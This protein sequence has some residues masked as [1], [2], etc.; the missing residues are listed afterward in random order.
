MPPPISSPPTLDELR[1]YYA[2]LNRPKEM[3]SSPPPLPA[4]LAGVSDAE[5]KLLLEKLI[6]AAETRHT[7][8]P[9]PP[10]VHNVEPIV[11]KDSDPWAQFKSQ[12]LHDSVYVVT[13]IGAVTLSFTCP[14]CGKVNNFRR[15]NLPNVDKCKHCRQYLDLRRVDNGPCHVVLLSGDA[16]ID[17]TKY[18]LDNHVSVPIRHRKWKWV[19]LCLLVSGIAFVVSIA[20][21][22]YCRNKAEQQQLAENAEFAK[23]K[24]KQDSQKLDQEA[25]ATK[26]QEHEQQA[27]QENQQ[28]LSV[29]RQPRADQGEEKGE[30]QIDKRR[31]RV[32]SIGGSKSKPSSSKRYMIESRS[33]WLFV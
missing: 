24:L 8:P 11:L 13:W 9:A 32:W 29:E 30:P 21:L 17:V 4:A 10:P 25:I 20:I 3:R 2:W 19:C 5:I 26:P 22:N 33:N 18:Q 14:I 12:W 1:T 31:W 15:R 23:I 7:L 27:V 16:E 28:Q 6:V